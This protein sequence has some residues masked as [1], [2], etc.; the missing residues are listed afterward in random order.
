MTMAFAPVQASSVEMTGMMIQAISV[1]PLVMAGVCFFVGCYHGWVAL[2]NIQP[3]INA[4]FAGTCFGVAL[5]DIFCAALYNSKSLEQG[6]FWQHVQIETALVMFLSFCWFLHH[7]TRMK[8]RK[9]M[10]AI[11]GYFAVLFLLILMGDGAMTLSPDRPA[12]KSLSLWGLG[13]VTYHEAVPGFL[14][15]LAMASEIVVL[16]VFLVITFRYARSMKYQGTLFLFFSICFL[17]AAVVNDVLVSMNL[18]ASFYLIEYFFLIIVADMTYMLLNQYV[19]SHENYE[20]LS[21]DLENR[22]KERTKDLEKALSRVRHLAAKAESSNIAKS[23]FLANMSHEIRT[24]MNGLIGFT[25]LLAETS[26]DEDQK[27][28]VKT[29]KKSGDAL[30]SLLNDILDFSKIEAGELALENIAFDIEGLCYDVC[31]LLRPRIGSKPVA[32]I[33]HVEEEVPLRVTGDPNR[34]RQ[35]LSN[36]MGNASKFTEQGEIELHLSLD[37][38]RATGYI[39]HG[40]VRD[41]GDGIP[42]NKLAVIFEPFQQADNSDTRRYGGTGLGLSICRQI[43]AL[44][45]GR[46]WVESR[47]GEGSAF[48]F[49]VFL[50]KADDGEDLRPTYGALSGKRALVFDSHSVNLGFIAAMLE[51]EGMAVTGI[52]DGD[53]IVPALEKALKDQSPFD[54]FVSSI[55]SADQAIFDT[56]EVIRRSEAPLCAIP[57]IALSSVAELMWR[58]CEKAGYDAYLPLPVRKDKLC[59]VAAR[60]LGPKDQEGEDGGKTSPLRISRHL[61]KEDAPRVNILLGEDNPV[62]QKLARVLLKKMGYHVDVAENGALVVERYLANPGAY[63]IILMDVHMPEMDGLAAT[64]A[65]RAAGHDRVPIIAMTAHAMKGFRETCIDAGMDDYISKPIQKDRVHDI[66]RR[67]GRA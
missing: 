33:C 26:L 41:T 18:Y 7:L 40:T 30:L 43:I 2:R 49:K 54:L 32:L 10:W 4:S 52:A 44:M 13:P 27:D 9:T 14:V 58:R 56:A 66:I 21:A 25:D 57:M 5:Y 15:Q 35:V 39:I 63:Q 34:L 12:V 6:V 47:V 42:E 53:A 1:P 24:P 67:W 38:E 60:L 62:N 37:E 48:H 61:M 46:L 16:L 3:Q 11:T 55:R 51:K 31:D 22:V 17:I 23:A 19:E 20:T 36:L 45:D 64:R 65:I 28:Y 59:R 50:R 8:S 29:I